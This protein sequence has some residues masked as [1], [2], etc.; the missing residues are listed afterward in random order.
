MIDGT[1]AEAFAPLRDVLDRNLA[2]GTDVGA[3]LAVVH[4]GELVADLWGGEARPG[5]P[6]T[7]D[8]IVQ[9]WSVT[10]TMVGLAVLVL[11]DRGEID[12]DAPVASYWPEFGAAG[13]ERVLVRHLMGH[14]SGLPGW[15]APITAEQCIDLE[16]SEALLAAQ[17]PWYEPGS[18][19]AYQIIDHGHL[20]DGVVRAATGRPLA[21]VLREEVV[22]PLSGGS[23]GFHLGVPDDALAHCADLLP[24]PPSQLDYST[25]PPDHFLIR[26]AINPVLTT[27]FC[28]DTPWRRSTVGGAAGHGN[29]RGIA[30][31]QSVVSHGGEVGG[32]RL[33]SPETVDRIWEVQASGPDLVLM[34]PLTYG[35]GYALPTP[36]A[37]AVPDGKVCWWTGYG[38]SI[39]VNDAER[40]TTVAYAMNQM[41]DHMVG[42]PRT[43]EYVATAF[44][45][46]EKL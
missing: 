36:S 32:V 34:A 19:P 17:A 46:L 30:Q 16:A 24:P 15:D 11:A 3:S 20:L 43:D 26:T 2:D 4:D 12:L 45:C 31:V 21:E 35:M 1:C 25:L 5:V 39:V 18:A 6:W 40:R 44:A 29:A 41:A 22:V 33:L 9:V 10:K 23:P 38:G 28:N 8:T 7:R 42:S 14:T 13:K 27:G 37:P